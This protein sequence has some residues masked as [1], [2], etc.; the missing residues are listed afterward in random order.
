M[1]NTLEHMVRRGP[2]FTEM[3]HVYLRL[4]ALIMLGAGLI[5]WARIVGAESWRGLYFPDMPTEWQ[6]AI[7]FFAVLDLIAAI[8]LWLLASWGTVIWLFRSL[9]QVVMH[10][11]FAETFARRPYEIAFYMGAIALYLVLLYLSER[12]GEEQAKRS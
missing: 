1:R 12:F 10:T 3:L 4:M 11:V 5:H 8:G 9:C 6:S 7:V 2:S